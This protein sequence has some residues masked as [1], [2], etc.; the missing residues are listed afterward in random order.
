MCSFVIQFLICGSSDAVVE[1]EGGGEEEEGGRGG[2][3]SSV[4]VYNERSNED[5]QEVFCQQHIHIQ[6]N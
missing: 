5:K 1:E 2:V 4:I 6:S 3:P